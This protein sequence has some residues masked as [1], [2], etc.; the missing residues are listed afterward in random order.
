MEKQKGNK[1][2]S[3]LKHTIV[4]GAGR[5][6]SRVLSVLLLPLFT[7][8]LIP[9]E[10]GLW[11]L[12]VLY[13]SAIMAISQLGLNNSLF[14]FY[15]LA[16]KKHRG[17]VVFSVILGMTGFSAL[18]IVAANLLKGHLSMLLTGTDIHA[19][20]VLLATIVGVLDGLFITLS[21]LYRIE[22]RP[23][24]YTAYSIAQT[25]GT[26]LLAII[27]IVLFD[28]GVEGI[29][30]AFAIGNFLVIIPLLWNAFSRM[31]LHFDAA[32]FWELL[33]YGIPFV[34]V[35]LAT[36]IFSLIDRWLL[37]YILGMHEVGL[38]SAGYKIASFVL[39]VLTAF[40]FA[41]S[42]RMYQ[43]YKERKLMQYLPSLYKK[44]G[45]LLAAASC[46]VIFF[47]REVF[48][49][50]ISSDDYMAGVWIA[51]IVGVAYYFD[52]IS[53]LAESGIY[54]KKRTGVLPIIT[55]L[56]AMINISLNL[57]LIPKIGINGAAIATVISYIVLTIFYIRADRLLLRVK[58]PFV[59][60]LVQLLI[61]AIAFAISWTSPHILFRIAG[62]VLSL[63]ALILTMGGFGEIRKILY[64]FR[65]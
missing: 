27:F 25:A 34:P 22:E 44:L 46:F 19:M 12:L 4:Y 33:I 9:S 6:L 24:K 10:F 38:Y 11:Q 50:L 61:M 28:Y 1:K 62:F 55:I 52:G 53:L 35:L 21:L 5:V 54:I 2:V 18:I 39:L 13:S 43:L 23:M 42:P 65:R 47:G 41:W 3:L 59:T 49:I 29:F 15:I 17:K 16:A 7:N 64:I 57:Y 31:D 63:I 45:G 58:I 30:Y 37:R 56:G 32:L 14:R 26:L 51:P 60:L 48:D 8:Y 40:R 36:M 20:L